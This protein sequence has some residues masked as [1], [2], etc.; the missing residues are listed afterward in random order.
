MSVLKW[1]ARAFHL[2]YIHARDINWLGWLP[3]GR[4]R[5]KTH[6][7]WSRF[8]RF[9]SR[10]EQPFSLWGIHVR[11][12]SH[13][14]SRG[15]PDTVQIKAWCGSAQHNAALTPSKDE[16]ALGSFEHALSCKGR[17]GSC[18]HSTPPLNMKLLLR[19]PQLY[20]QKSQ[21][22][23]FVCKTL[24]EL[25]QG[26]VGR[27]VWRFRSLPVTWVTPL[28]R[29]HWNLVALQTNKSDENRFFTTSYKLMRLWG[30]LSSCQGES[31]HESETTEA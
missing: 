12:C 4:K 14:V 30:R 22:A 23:S 8:F 16:S 18:L 1:P 24:G 9:T 17:H 2:F 7:K 26:S 3:L 25:S 5:S 10:L 19:V 29:T 20:M 21:L 6:L 28:G 13:S 15:K 27:C 11:A 31:S